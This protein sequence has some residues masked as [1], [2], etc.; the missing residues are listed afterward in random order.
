M[1]VCHETEMPDTDKTSWQHVQ[2]KSPNELFGGNGHLFLF[3]A[4]SV[5]AP[6][7]RHVLAVERNQSM[8]GNGNAM[9]V[10]TEVPDDLFGATKRWLGVDNPVFAE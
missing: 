3:V 6:S 2:K 8:I 4:V 10:A 9:R 1:G 7:K 5:I